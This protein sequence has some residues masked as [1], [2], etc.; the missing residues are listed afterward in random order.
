M[1]HNRL[2]DHA[3]WKHSTPDRHATTYWSAQ[4]YRDIRDDPCASNWLKE[5]LESALRRDIVD[6]VNDAEA[7]LHILKDR[8]EAFHGPAP[9][10][11]KD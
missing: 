4:A 6:C 3:Y 11:P 8:L 2:E 10:N 9:V 5:A 7:L 1:P